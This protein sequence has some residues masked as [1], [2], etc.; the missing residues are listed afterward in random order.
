[1][2]KKLL[3]CIIV[4]AFSVFHFSAAAQ[5]EAA[6]GEQGFAVINANP[7]YRLIGARYDFWDTVA[8]AWYFS[9][10]MRYIYTKVTKKLE[11]TETYQFKAGKWERVYRE[12]YK[13]DI[14]GNRTLLERQ[15]W[16]GTQWVD[17]R[18]VIYVYDGNNLLVATQ[19]QRWQPP[20]WQ[21]VERSLYGYDDDKN[22]IS[23]LKEKPQNNAWVKQILHLYRYDV[24]KQLVEDRTLRWSLNNA[25]FD[26][27][28]IVNY[29]WNSTGKVTGELVKLWK[30]SIWENNTRVSRD[31]NQIHQIQ[32][33]LREV[34]Q[35]G[36]WRV[37]SQQQ[38][39]HQNSNL[40]EV[41]EYDWSSTGWQK[42]NLY[43][44]RYDAAGNQIY[45][46]YSIGQKENWLK[47][48]Q[49][50][51]YYESDLV[52][53]SQALDE[54]AFEVTPNPCTDWLQI[55]YNNPA[56]PIRSI[57]IMDTGGK[58]VFSKIIEGN[59][60]LETLQLEGLATGTYHLR[61]NTQSGKQGV[62]QIVKVQ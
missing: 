18:R 55:R 23:W 1:M 45:L 29:E 28:Q 16:N 9:D 4:Q 33:Q 35:Q 56:D 25:E 39:E 26:P 52:P 32:H 49:I 10:S 60:E 40:T 43:E 17:N 58:R 59:A 37:Y 34:W 3:Y 21:D 38:F 51:S 62:K 36:E 8:Q 12:E 53:V 31:Y 48:Q 14:K 7:D 27:I 54:S 13:Y 44:N 6:P 19:I 47:A 57:S 2:N 41:A 30:D 61:L 24:N 11:R 22:R 46:R 15:L 5:T 42:K 20:V 50:F